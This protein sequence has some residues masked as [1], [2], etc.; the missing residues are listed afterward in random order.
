MDMPPVFTTRQS[1]SQESKV[2]LAPIVHHPPT[3]G[4]TEEVPL[5]LVSCAK[6]RFPRCSVPRVSFLLRNRRVLP[7]APCSFQSPADGMVPR[8]TYK[9]L[10]R[11]GCNGKG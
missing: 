9:Y 5:S 11:A 3:V 1:N 4:H 6:P 8:P 10:H 7:L 2:P